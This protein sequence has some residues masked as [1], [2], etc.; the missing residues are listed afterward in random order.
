[1]L[2]YFVAIWHISWPYGIVY[3][4]LVNLWSFGIFTPVLY[5]VPRNP[6]LEYHVCRP[7]L[8]KSEI[9][10][11]VGKNGQRQIPRLNVN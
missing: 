4:H 3:G 8:S 5:I 11:K 6:D 7:K 2:V 9:E 1:V 10:M